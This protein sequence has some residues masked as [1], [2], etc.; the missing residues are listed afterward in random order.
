MAL[1]AP[2]NTLHHLVRPLPRLPRT[3]LMQFPEETGVNKWD[4]LLCTLGM[5]PVTDRTSEPEEA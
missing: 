3:A 2:R 1:P 4:I 5:L